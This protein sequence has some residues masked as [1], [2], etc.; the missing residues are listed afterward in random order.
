MLPQSNQV[1]KAIWEAVNPH[2]GKKRIDEAFPKELRETTREAEMF[3]KFKCGSTWQAL[4]SDNY[5]G[6]I[7][8]TPAGI[9]YSEWAQAN[10]AARGFLRPILAENKGWQLFITTPRGKNH[11]HRTYKAAKK[12]PGAFAQLLTAEQTGVYSVE[13]LEAEKAEYLSTYGQ[14]M[15]EA[16]YN[17]EYLCSFDAAI[18]GAIW[19]AELASLERNGRFSQFE[20]D[21]KYPVH[22]A[23]DIGRTDAT[24]IWWYQVIANEVR[25]IDYL[26]DNFKD[27]DFYASQMLGRRV[28]IDIV[29]SNIVVKNQDD[30]PTDWPKAEHRQK[31]R[32]ER[33]SIPHDAKAKTLA[34]K[35]S[36]EEQ[37]RAVF[38]W[39]KV[40]VLPLLSREDGIK[41]VRQMLRKTWI[42]ERCE[43]GWEALKAYQY[44]WDERL[45]KFKDTPLHNWASNPADG[46]R[47]VAT[48]WRNEYQQQPD[49]DR[50]KRD[51]YGSDD[52]DENEWKTA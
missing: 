9:V 29:D 34:T 51:A 27:V 52:D 37:F 3:I 15:G 41:Y 42:A 49:T 40:N 12:T 26:A 50:K 47:Y 13:Q 19:G 30:W 25:I 8:S 17:Q 1:R 32:Y 35:K 14:D 7:G 24:A 46:L 44:E 23:M 16:L 2:T 28:I 33:I 20:H 18:L 48:A 36:V 6:S 4:G 10:P 39:G 22:V 5:E 11:A 38:G 43:E 45:Q 31:Y 21:P